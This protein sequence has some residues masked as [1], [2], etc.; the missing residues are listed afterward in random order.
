MSK[1][2]IFSL[3]GLNDVGKNM[4]VVNVDDEIFVFDAGLKYADDKMLGVDYIIPDYTYI[5]KNIDKV[6]GIFITH[7]H[8]QQMGALADIVSDLKNIDIYATEFTSEIIKDEF[9]KEGISTS[10]LKTIKPHKKINFKNA[11]VFPI[12]LTHSVPDNVGYVINT[13]D[14]AIVYTGNF[15]FDPSMLGAYQTDIGKLAYIGKQGVL[16]L[17]SESLYAEKVGFTSPNHRTTKVI[18][19]ALRKNDSRVIF[20]IYGTQFYRIQEIFNEVMKVGRNIVILGKDLET[21][22]M[23]AIDNNYLRFDKDRIFNLKHIEDGNIVVIVS[24]NLEK[25]FSNIKRVIRG[26]DKFLKINSNDTVVFA[27]QVYDGMEKTATDI[28]DEVAKLGANLIIVSKKYL[29]LHASREDLML[30]LNLMKPKYYFPVIGE[31]RHQV[32]NADVATTIGMPKENVL[33]KLNGDVISFV[34]GSLVETGEKIE[35]DDI[36]IDGKTV[37]D[38]G[39]IV[40]K[41]RESLSQSGIVLV[42]FTIDKETKKVLAGPEILTRGFVYVKDN[43]DLIKE[44]ENIST[45]IIES[46]SKDHYIDFNQIRSEIRDK[47]GKY[48]YQ[49]TECKPMMLSVIQEI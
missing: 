37:G 25:P 32:C 22:I 45:N 11:S 49:E 46:N 29:S 20:N 3:G 21:T 16:C 36:L 48:L 34:N 10:H 33:L 30:M 13:S 14:G 15:V 38:I 40:L 4:Y 47:V 19:E 17:M 31:Y 12:S 9:N 2:K 7:G 35:T 44:I 26:F 43:I 23:K 5:K 28:F 6:K 1:I 39:E 24:D 42:T 41:D 18:K 27:N 8:D